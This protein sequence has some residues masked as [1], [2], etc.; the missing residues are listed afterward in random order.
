MR[1]GRKAPRQKNRLP[2]ATD[3]RLGTVG[4]FPVAMP[5]VTKSN[6]VPDRMERNAEDQAQ[7]L[8]VEGHPKYFVSHW[9]RCPECPRAGYAIHVTAVKTGDGD[10]VREAGFRYHD[11]A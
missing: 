4:L 6:T 10:P 1:F 3:V 5:P 2:A 11:R 8:I 9:L 7:V